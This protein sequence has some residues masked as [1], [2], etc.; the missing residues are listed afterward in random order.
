MKVEVDCFGF[1]E[2]KVQDLSFVDEIK[3]MGYQS[4][5]LAFLSER[6]HTKLDSLSLWL[7]FDIYKQ[8]LREFQRSL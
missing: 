4:W 5:F 3:K 8:L 1:N 6:E 2:Q 7:I